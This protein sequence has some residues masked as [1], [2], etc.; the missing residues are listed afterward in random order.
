MPGVVPFVKPRASQEA[1]V[2]LA[3][4]TQ[5]ISS[6]GF[7]IVVAAWLLYRDYVFLNRL[8]AKLDRVILLLEEVAR[9]KVHGS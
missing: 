9:G 1:A 3:S 8:S 5:V 2:D 6:L 7:P 4:V